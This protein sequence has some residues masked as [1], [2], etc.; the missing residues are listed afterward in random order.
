MSTLFPT[1]YSTLSSKDLGE[2]IEEKYGFNQVLCTFLLRGVSD[3]Y[4]VE[5]SA[6]KAILKIYRDVHRSLNE[7]NGEVELLTILKAKGGK[8]AEALMDLEGKPIQ[9]FQAAEGIRHGV[10]FRYA[11]GTNAYDLTDEQLVEIGREM[12]VNHSITSQIELSYPREEYTIETTI[13]R[14]LEVLKPFLK[15]LPEEYQYLQETAVQ[16]RQ[17]MNSFDLSSFGYGYCH[18]DYLPKNFHFDENNAITVFDYDFAGKGFLMNDIMTFMMHYFFHTTLN[19]ISYEEGDRQFAIF[20]DAYRKV[21]PVSDQELA[22]MPYLGFGFWLFYLGFQ[23]EN[24]DDWSN[25]FFSSRYLQD[26]VSL[27]KKYM[28]RY[29]KLS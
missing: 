27:I 6:G 2:Y 23:C 9:S 26:R 15:D 20:I 16:V 4:V 19:R 12:A 18:Y 13:D 22:L 1:Q 21:R 29:C 8:V 3:T 14:P 7:I 28:N 10:V 24:F 25:T 5:H 17:K 11:P